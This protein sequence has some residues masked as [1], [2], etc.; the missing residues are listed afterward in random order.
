MACLVGKADGTGDSGHTSLLVL[1]DSR[2][3]VRSTRGIFPGS[4]GFP[5]AI[6][7]K[8]GL[9]GFPQPLGRIPRTQPL[10]S[11]SSCHLPHL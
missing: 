7:S 1:T 9:H 11:R 5:M 10:A 2:K 4:S 6:G 3:K 8:E